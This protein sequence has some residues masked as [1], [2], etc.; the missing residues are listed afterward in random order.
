MSQASRPRE[1]DAVTYDLRPSKTWVSFIKGKFKIYNT[2]C[3]YGYDTEGRNSYEWRAL[4]IRG[5]D[6]FKWKYDL[7]PEWLKNETNLEANLDVSMTYRNEE[8]VRR[9]DPEIEIINEKIRD[10]EA[11][12]E[13]EFLT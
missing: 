8:D 4:V 9:N 1:W 6:E 10:E 11:E 5:I 7:K 12:E 13:T 2:I 3:A